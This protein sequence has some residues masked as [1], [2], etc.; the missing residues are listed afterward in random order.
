METWYAHLNRFKTTQ[1]VNVQRGQ[2]IGDMGSTGNSTGSHLHFMALNGGWP[3]HINP[4]PYMQGGGDIPDAGL[5]FDPIGDIAKGLLNSFRSQFPAGAIAA[6]AAFGMGGKL[7]RDV[8]GSVMKSLGMGST[9]GPSVFDNGGWMDTVG[10]NRSG[11]P[12]AVFNDRQWDTM[13]T[14]AARGASLDGYTLELNADMTRATLRRD[15]RSAAVEVL[16]EYNV[17]IS[18][19]RAR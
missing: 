8:G 9:Y 4:G 2:R 6:D 14:L 16:D 5:P 19:G 12:E 7:L 11:K 15:A 1:G 10:V 13:H 17:D 3:R 18:R